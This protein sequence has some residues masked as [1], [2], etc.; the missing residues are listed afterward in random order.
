M[1]L[2]DLN[3]RKYFL[4]FWF[5]VKIIF[6]HMQTKALLSLM[7]FSWGG[8]GGLS[9]TRNHTSGPINVVLG[10]HRIKLEYE[11]V[12]NSEASTLI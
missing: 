9:V 1:Y 5:L 12:R 6:V 4:E 10:M 3:A 8:G 11:K 2:F 7:G